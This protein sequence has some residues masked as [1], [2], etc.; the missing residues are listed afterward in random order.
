MAARVARAKGGKRPPSAAAQEAWA[1]IVSLI[2][3]D[4]M[5]DRMHAACDAVDLS[6]GLAKALQSLEPGRTRP[7]GE[8]ADGWRCDASYATSVV[9]GLEARGLVERQTRATDRRVRTVVLTSA[10]L[11][12]KEQLR[13]ALSEPPEGFRGLTARDASELR[14]LLQRVLADGE[15]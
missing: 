13:A 12:A 8:L 11:A 1:L 2:F 3:S 4:V 9:D 6:P 5:H 14:S 7:M 15:P 10:G